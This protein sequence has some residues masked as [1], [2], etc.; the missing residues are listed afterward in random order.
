MRMA[1]N[2]RILHVPMEW[3][4]ESC[5]TPLKNFTNYKVP[6]THYSTVSIV[7]QTIRYIVWTLWLTKSSSIM[8]SVPH[9]PTVYHTIGHLIQY[10]LYYYKESCIITVSAPYFTLTY[11]T[12]GYLVWTPPL[13]CKQ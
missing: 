6:S 5:P 12:T 10:E 11:L 4:N 2:H 7:Y 9:L 8:V 1:R 13:H 3:M